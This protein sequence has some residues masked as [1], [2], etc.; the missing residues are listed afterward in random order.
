MSDTCPTC[1]CRDSEC[2]CDFCDNPDCT[3]SEDENEEIAEYRTSEETIRS[4]VTEL[5]HTG[6]FDA[7]D[8]D[9]QGELLSALLE[10]LDHRGTPYATQEDR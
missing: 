8:N 6:R 2:G 10:L 7:L 1:G 9:T 4:Y 3:C 5:A